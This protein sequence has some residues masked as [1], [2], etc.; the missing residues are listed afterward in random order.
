[1]VER[2]RDSGASPEFS[3]IGRPV[4]WSAGAHDRSALRRGDTDTLVKLLFLDALLREQGDEP[5]FATV[6]PGFAGTEACFDSYWTLSR[7]PLDTTM[8]DSLEDAVR[9]GSIDSWTPTGNERLD[10]VLQEYRQR[11]KKL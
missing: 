6:F 11:L 4:L 7:I 3:S 8:E 9:S 5:Q 1:M 10:G 2:L